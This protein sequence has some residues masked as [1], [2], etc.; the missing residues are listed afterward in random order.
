MLA[1]ELFRWWY[2]AGWQQLLRAISRQLTGLAE[3][4][5]VGTLLRTLFAPWRRIISYAGAGLD[6]KFRAMLDNLISR[7]V[8]FVVRLL[9]LMTVAVLLILTVALGLAALVIWPLVPLLAVLA[10]IKGLA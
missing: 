10:L 8:G 1:I 4:F 9:V 6:A 7:A 2:S 3:A 5:S